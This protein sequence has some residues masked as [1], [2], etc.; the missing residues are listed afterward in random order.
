MLMFRSP[1]YIGQSLSL[2]PG[3]RTSMLRWILK[4]LKYRKSSREE[5]SSPTNSQ[6]KLV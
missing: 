4:N 5:L 6:T 3:L 1:S 2:E